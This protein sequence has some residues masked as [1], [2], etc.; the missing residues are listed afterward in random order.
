[1]NESRKNTNIHDTPMMLYNPI[2]ACAMRSDTP[3]P[4]NNG[5]IL[6]ISITPAPSCC[7]KQSW[8]VNSGKPKIMDKKMNWKMKLAPKWI[9]KI[10]N[11]ERLKS[12]RVQPRHAIMELRLWGQ[13]PR[14]LSTSGMS[15]C[16]FLSHDLQQ[17]VVLNSVFVRIHNWS[18]TYINI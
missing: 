13:W 17:K 18:K 1:M 5:D 15:V 3:T 9:V 11:R 7:P 4:W 2:S 6:H 14:G 12:P 16:L 8:R 10:A